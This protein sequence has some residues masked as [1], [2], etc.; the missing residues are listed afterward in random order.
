MRE[1]LTEKRIHQREETF[2]KCTSDTWSVANCLINRVLRVVEPGFSRNT[3]KTIFEKIDTWMFLSCD[4]YR[5]FDCCL[6]FL[7]TLHLKYRFCAFCLTKYPLKDLVTKFY[8]VLW[9]LI[10][11]CRYRKVSQKELRNRLVGCR[12]DAEEGQVQTY[13]PLYLCFVFW[14]SVFNF[15]FAA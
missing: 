11:C 3:A 6:F 10:P 13:L 2:L 12:R 15:V 14:V 4:D 9:V 5:C 1:K 7:A 8:V